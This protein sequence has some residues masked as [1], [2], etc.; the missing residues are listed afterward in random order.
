MQRLPIAVFLAFILAGCGRSGPAAKP[1]RADVGG[2]WVSERE[3]RNGY[4][5]MRVEI[6]GDW[7]L[8]KGADETFNQRAVDFIAGDENNLRGAMKS[9][10]EQTR[11]IFWAYRH[12]LG[13]PGKSNPN[14][15]V[16]IENVTR[17]PGIKSA[18]DYLQAMEQTL[19]LSNK[20]FNFAPE[21]KAVDVGGVAFAM[22]EAEMPV[23][24]LT[25]RQRYYARFNNGYVLLMGV[26]VMAEGDEAEVAKVTA[27]V[28][29]L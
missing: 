21:T 24:T 26:T 13:T 28:R 6:P 11:T 1:G 20:T 14:V 23:G 3:Y 4:F 27:T 5:G 8:Q 16:L 15:A 25:V 22:R 12:P 9:A 19:K 29:A 18:A 17:L 7:S 2:A 10:I